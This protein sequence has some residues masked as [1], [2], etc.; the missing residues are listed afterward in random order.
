M[1]SKSLNPKQSTAGPVLWASTWGQVPLAPLLAARP[2]F[3][4]TLSSLECDCCCMSLPPW[5]PWG[6][7]L[8]LFISE[9]LEPNSVLSPETVPNKCFWVNVFLTHECLIH[10]L[11]VQRAFLF[12]WHFTAWKRKNKGPKPNNSSTFYNG[13][14]T[15]SCIFLA[16]KMFL[17]LFISLWLKPQSTVV[18]GRGRWAWRWPGFKPR[19]VTPWLMI[20]LSTVT[21]SMKWGQ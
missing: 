7:G 10:T 12:W 11:L 3:H 2:F 14:S 18:K 13:I 20:C 15:G 19:S 6:L 4:L 16:L 21:S 17:R 8:V 5:V 1:K 9:S